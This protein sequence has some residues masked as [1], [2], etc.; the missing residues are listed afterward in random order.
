MLIA[1][2]LL[3]LYKFNF[4]LFLALKPLQTYT[5]TQ[6]SN[7]LSNLAPQGWSDFHRILRTHPARDHWI[8]KWFPGDTED[9][10]SWGSSDYPE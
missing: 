2:C 5:E 4:G 1:N 7:L 9:L 6:K 10:P 8:L 3:L